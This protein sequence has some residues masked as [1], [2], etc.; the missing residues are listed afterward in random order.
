MR[1]RAPGPDVAERLIAEAWEAGALGVEEIGTVETAEAAEP[2][3]GVE[4]IIYLVASDEAL[5]QR[6]L[7]RFEA[8]GARIAA[9]ERVEP[10]DWVEAWKQG[11]GEIEISPRL[12]VRPS[13]VDPVVRPGQ[14]E[15]VIDPG[16]AFG[17]GGHASTRL[18][19]EWIDALMADP[20][21]APRRVLDVGTGTGVLAQAAV[22]LGADCAVGFDLD[23]V[24][25]REAGRASRR[26]QVAG[27]VR[28]F[29]GP[30]GALR[31]E[32]FDLVIANL[33]K[34]EVLPIAHEVAR[35]VRP[36][37]ILVL[38]GLLA[39]DRDEVAAAF[40]RH[41]LVARALRRQRDEGGDDWI[42]PLLERPPA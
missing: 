16:Q 5:M 36:G 11:L 41:S 34:R 14:C 7:E 23:R 38:S 39:A 24:A 27:R 18:A 42:A 1:V 33:L 13:F 26:N 31:A 21:R 2:G 15:L 17:T 35:A 12:V 20:E 6:A 25:M 19:L 8:E 9:A 29:A 10:V 40:A 28:L 3:K 22:K 30:I 32:P 4:L 37:G